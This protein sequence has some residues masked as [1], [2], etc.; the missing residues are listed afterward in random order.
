MTYPQHD[1]AKDV[2]NETQAIGEFLEWLLSNRVLA[3]YHEHT[4]GCVNPDYR[5][6]SADDDANTWDRYFCGYTNGMLSPVR[7]HIESLIAE[8]YGIDYKAYYAEKEAMY[9]EIRRAAK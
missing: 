4:E 1:K 7:C 2:R 3:E 8:F 5:N 6:P 9:Q